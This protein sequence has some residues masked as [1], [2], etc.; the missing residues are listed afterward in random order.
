MKLLS[1]FAA[2]MVISTSVAAQDAPSVSL[3][4]RMQLRCSAA[5]ALVANGQDNGNEASLA[6]PDLR[7]RGQEFFV[8]STAR[9]MEQAGLDREQISQLLSEEAQDIWENDTLDQIMPVCLGLLEN[10]GL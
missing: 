2:I 3:E 8:V 9:V 10:S 7:E 1:T 5:F 6:Y 4:Q